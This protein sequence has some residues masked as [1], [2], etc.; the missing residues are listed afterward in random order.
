MTEA[1]RHPVSQTLAEEI[2]VCAQR[3]RDAQLAEEIA[4]IK[5]DS[6]VDGYRHGLDRGRELERAVEP[7]PG[8]DPIGSPPRRELPEVRRRDNVIDAVL[9]YLGAGD[10]DEGNSEGDILGELK[11]L[12]ERSVLAALAR[13]TD[14]GRLERSGE[15]GQRRY[16]LP[17]A[18]SPAVAADPGPE[19]APL[20]RPLEATDISEEGEQDRQPYKTDDEALGLIVRFGDIGE[21]QLGQV[22]IS[23]ETIA[24]LLQAELI[25][26]YPTPH[27]MRYRAVLP[28]TNE[29]AG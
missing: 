4:K 5:Y 12:K 15:R 16:R 21:A 18:A 28:E 27:G 11:H 13:L 22:H 24:E 8:K 6:W 25:E 3:T 23:Q 14:S 29:A 20:E 1:F 2:A 9:D 26:E 10:P 7:E 19:Q 17:P